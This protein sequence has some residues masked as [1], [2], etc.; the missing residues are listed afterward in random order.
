MDKATLH[1]KLDAYLKGSLNAAEQAEVRQLIDSDKEVAEHLELVRLEQE[2]AEVMVN[3]KLEE[4]MKAWN[5]EASSPSAIS[6][7]SPRPHAGNFPGKWTIGGL[8]IIVFAGLLIWS[9]PSDE[10]REAFDVVT[11]TPSSSPQ[12]DETGPSGSASN[13]AESLQPPSQETM[14]APGSAEQEPEASPPIA[15]TKETT[16]PSAEMQQLALAVANTTSPI[17]GLK[18]VK[19]GAQ[20]NKSPLAKGYRL[21]GE[22]KLD[23]AEPALLTVPESQNRQY[24][25]AQQYL[26]FIYFEKGKY[27]QVIPI[28]ENL[29]QQPYSQQAEMEW[30]L[31]LSYLATENAKGLDAL[32]QVATQSAS[33]DIRQKAQQLLDEINGLD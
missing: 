6:D 24:L 19:R 20:T 7:S 32:K 5:E 11:E 8:V 22:G 1:E 25:N 17:A 13:K 16:S 23:E 18:I 9:W 33:A 12:S 26:A 29:T 30:Y 10:E 2:L 4:M 21:M 27:E 3:E 28:L 14:P 15:N 31:A